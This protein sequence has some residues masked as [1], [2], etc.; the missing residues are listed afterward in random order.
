MGFIYAIKS[1]YSK[2]PAENLF[3]DILAER[4]AC[5]IQPAQSPS[6]KWLLHLERHF[7][8]NKMLCCKLCSHFREQSFETDAEY[9]DL[10]LMPKT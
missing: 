3:P 9:L 5:L 4:P 10:K 7:F 1:K 8:T 2:T 6:L